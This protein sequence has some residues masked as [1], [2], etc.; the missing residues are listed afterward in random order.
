MQ[1]S[2][3][4]FDPDSYLGKEF[5][6]IRCELQHKF[7][8]VEPWEVI[9]FLQTLCILIHDKIQAAFNDT[10]SLSHPFQLELVLN[11]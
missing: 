8:I 4:D 6:L 1:K 11:T 3:I 7:A 10:F 5:N 9:L 2:K